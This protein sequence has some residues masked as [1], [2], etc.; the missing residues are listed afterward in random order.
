M[1][2]TQTK[3]GW[4]SAVV[5]V[6]TLGLG[7]C[8]GGA[9]FK[10]PNNS[11]RAAQANNSTVLSSS[12]A[13]SSA[14][15]PSSYAPSAPSPTSD[16]FSGPAPEPASKS[17][18]SEEAPSASERPGLGTEWGETRYSH[19]SHSSF[20]RADPARPTQVVSLFYNDREGARAMARYADYREMGDA[21]VSAPGLDVS[22]ALNDDNGR[23]L[24]AF[25]ADG[26]TYAIG[27]AGQRYTL[28]VSNSTGMRI[29]AVATVDGLDV[30]DGKSGSVGKRGYIVP[31]GGNVE[32]DGFR[33]T[34]DHVAA[35][36]F[37][38]VRDSYAARTDS[39][40]N[41]GVIGVALF[42]PKGA[43]SWQWTRREV[44]RRESADPFPGRYASPPPPRW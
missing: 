36:R 15:A 35:F 1:M 17:S 7:A 2:K 27:E 11:G 12:R 41:V 16:A 26:R 13:P 18:R 19:V 8:G 33:Q 29:E 21:V 24:P 31:S 6:S 9:A 3:M 37:G 42:T 30:I 43:S 44:I 22:V 39:D 32:I 25:F 23:P 5:L 34:N 28:V 4:S 20:D 10:A 40:R 38:S 14:E